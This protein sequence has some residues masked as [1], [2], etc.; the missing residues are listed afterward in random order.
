M[1][2]EQLKL[3]HF[4]NSELILIQVMELFSFEIFDDKMYG[5]P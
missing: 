5:I 1:M 3:K 4:I 2:I